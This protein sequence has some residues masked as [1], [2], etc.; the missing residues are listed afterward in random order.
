MKTKVIGAVDHLN[1][2]LPLAERQKKTEQRTSQCL[3]DDFKKLR[4][5]WQN[6]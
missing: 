3:Q 5:T 6:A 4:R 1:K 2:I